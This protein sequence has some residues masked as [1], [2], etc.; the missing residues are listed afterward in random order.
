MH[1]NSRQKD[2]AD[3]T[4]PLLGK[5]SPHSSPP[6]TRSHERTAHITL[7]M[8]SVESESSAA[9][10]SG[11]TENASWWMQFKSSIVGKLCIGLVFIFIISFASYLGYRGWQHSNPDIPHHP[12]GNSP[13]FT[14]PPPKSLCLTP[15]CVT[16]AAQFIESINHTQNP[17]DDFY[18][19]AC[20]RW[21][22]NHD[23]PE[24]R[25]KIGVFNNLAEKN[26]HVVRR[27]LEGQSFQGKDY[28]LDN[29][30]LILLSKLRLAYNTCMSES[31]I[32]S[33]GPGPLY[34][35]AGQFNQTFKENYLDQEVLV[36]AL[37]DLS[38]INTNVLFETMVETH[39]DSSEKQVIY[40]SQP[41]LV[42]PSKTYYTDS[43]YIYILENTIQTV[44]E[45]LFP[46]G[47][48]MQKE[49]DTTPSQSFWPFPS[50]S[51][52]T[53]A[54]DIVIFEKQ[55]AEIS[56]DAQDIQDPL[57]T[58]NPMTITQLESMTTTIL[59]K[60]FFQ[61]FSQTLGLPKCPSCY[62]SFIVMSPSYFQAL[63][64]ILASTS[65]TTMNYYLTWKAIYS[66]IDRVDDKTKKL[67]QPFKAKVEGLLSTPPRFE[68]CIR[69]LDHGMGFATGRF[70]VLEQFF[71]ES[72]LKAKNMVTSIL[73]QFQLDLDSNT[74]MDKE[75]KQ[76]AQEKVK[77]INLKI[78]Y[79]NYLM[80][81][82]VLLG[83]FAALNL[84]EP[85]HF[86][87]ALQLRKNTLLLHWQKLMKPSDPDEWE[88]L[89][90][91]VN[92]Y[93][94]PSQNEIVFPAGILQ[95]PFFH[96]NVPDAL[97]FGGIGTVIGHEI[98]HGF[99]NHGRHFDSK[100]RLLDWWSSATAEAFEQKSQ[101]FVEQYSRFYILDP[102]K[103]PVFVNG[104]LTLGENLADNGGMKQSFETFRKQPPSLQL[105][106][107]MLNPEQ[108]FFLSFSHVWCGK[109]SPQNA[110]QG[111][112]TDPHSPYF[113]RVNAAVQNSDLFAKAFECPTKSP[114]RSESPCKLF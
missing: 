94:N 88:M 20:G 55:L 91:T 70:Y 44:F 33:V 39:P 92:A 106:G 9:M 110:L 103:N 37:V 51:W 21:V 8:S 25:S 71:G 22:D 10:L 56:W 14:S 99:D 73:H 12:P 114:M 11:T 95:P 86:Q 47:P 16:L 5:T 63:D 17:C 38:L 89:P 1:S 111:I 82:T 35:L 3:A 34:D 43:E 29:N 60:D 32:N 64:P 105:P 109:V 59:W 7:P 101:C 45:A 13:P 100:G 18:Q 28:R 6:S 52:Q 78:G 97:N 107:L 68:S 48:V 54:K 93:Y 46:K 62:T 15:E 87:H 69:W 49:E 66:M 36:K 104:N 79:P 72:K 24:D 85:N 19:Y 4:T 81:T 90:H 40:L 58:N 77:S 61:L 31:M 2:D 53:V 80:N 76:K 26:S 96:V 23:I 30:D 84:T 113:V 41:S 102:H 65:T 67:L 27:I 57:K 108:L 75:T 42:L 74:W 83:K 98:L 112:R 50:I